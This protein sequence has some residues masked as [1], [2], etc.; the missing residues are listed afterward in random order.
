MYRDAHKCAPVSAI[1]RFGVKNHSKYYKTLLS[2]YLLIV[3]VYTLV[4]V[5]V[6]TY[7]SYEQFSVMDGKDKKIMAEQIRESI[8]SRLI[9]QD[10]TER[11]IV[12]SEAFSNLL[13]SDSYL[14]KIIFSRELSRICGY[15]LNQGSRITVLYGNGSTSAISTGQIS[16]KC[17]F[18]D[19]MNFSDTDIMRIDEYILNGSAKETMFVASRY[20]EENMLTVF[21]KVRL[22][23]TYNVVLCYSY[24]FDYVLGSAV[25]IGSNE[26][27]ICRGGEV[28]I[29][30]HSFGD[31]D[32]TALAEYAKEL[33]G[34]EYGIS[35]A[36][37]R[38]NG[39]GCKIYAVNSEV[40]DWCYVLAVPESERVG[41]IRRIV[42]IATVILILA[43]G[44]GIVIIRWLTEMVYNP[45]RRLVDSADIDGGNL[46]DEFAALKN[47]IEKGK[48]RYDELEAY[49]REN[50]QGKENFLKDLLNNNIP[51]YEVADGIVKF[52]LEWL[53]EEC[54]IIV[55]AIVN[56]ENLQKE[57]GDIDF[58]NVRNELIELLDEKISETMTCEMVRMSADRFAA[59]IKGAKSENLEK[60]LIEQVSRIEYTTSVEIRVLISDMIRRTEDFA[61]EYNKISE[62]VNNRLAHSSVII[63]HG[64]G[65]HDKKMW[66]YPIELEKNLI[67]NTLSGSKESVKLS[68]ARLYEENFNGLMDERDYTQLIFAIC[69]T[70]DRILTVLKADSQT[71]FGNDDKLYNELALCENTDRMSEKISNTFLA[72]CDFI[73]KQNDEQGRDLASEMLRFVDENYQKEISLY[74]LAEVFN[75]SINYIS[76]V[77][78]RETGKNFKEYLSLRRVA[79]A[80]DFLRS[81]N[82][83]IAQVAGM[84]GC[85]NSNSFIRLFKRYEGITPGQYLES[86]KLT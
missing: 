50:K 4:L 58:Y 79:K 83:N 18:Y 8:D 72:L 57:F 77:F 21:K 12:Y 62:K 54:F 55:F 76:R 31:Y 59:V 48:S 63:E 20:G 30:N 71:V 16:A 14:D 3:T 1:W 29:S 40:Y 5:G 46:N 49:V 84:V 28:L 81:G 38:L 66:Y 35:D 64:D 47:A 17:D 22:F 44:A 11:Q 34:V 7:Y 69:A 23:P 2:I 15:F 39:Q 73:E 26:I 43:M 32:R 13:I 68:L 41:V 82:Y 10:A 61:R 9:L 67:E 45:V 78:T 36:K 52:S 6:F 86:I 37:M 25:H 51:A 27:S 75:Y 60:Y 42:I 56:M 33:S 65:V 74:D 80:K 53:A 85:A 70:V 19:D 24:S